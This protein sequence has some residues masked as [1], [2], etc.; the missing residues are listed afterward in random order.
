M[1]LLPHCTDDDKAGRPR[2]AMIDDRALLEHLCNALTAAALSTE[3]RTLM[4]AK[5]AE[6]DGWKIL[7][8][9]TQDKDMQAFF[10]SPFGQGVRSIEEVRRWFDRGGLT[11]D[12]M[13]RREALGIQAPALASQAARERSGA[14][15][16]ERQAEEERAP[17]AAA[18]AAGRRRSNKQRRVSWEPTTTDGASDRV[19]HARGKASVRTSGAVHRSL[20]SVPHGFAPATDLGGVPSRIEVLAIPEEHGPVR[21]SD[22]WCDAEVLVSPPHWCPERERQTRTFAPVKTERPCLPAAA[23]L[24]S[25]HRALSL[26]RPLPRALGSSR[27]LRSA[28]TRSTARTRCVGTPICASTRSIWRPFGG[29]RSRSHRSRR[30]NRRRGRKAAR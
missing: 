23:A 8:R 9:G 17:A 27:L 11:D 19:G 20:S 15:E 30:R 21:S 18:A 14:A 2:K 24:S 22:S 3:N 12:E 25:R 28:S 4:P 26:T 29:G 13:V 6:A 7:W 10:I 1:H 16:R 5:V